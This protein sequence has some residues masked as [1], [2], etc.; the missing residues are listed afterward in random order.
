MW[1]SVAT[2]NFQAD[3]LPAEPFSF[4]IFPANAVLDP[5]IPSIT[6]NLRKASY[7]AGDSTFVIVTA[8]FAPD[9]SFASSAQKAVAFPNPW[10]ASM[11]VP[12]CMQAS[13][14]TQVEIRD[15]SGLVWQ[16]REIST[17]S[18]RACWSA[19][20][21]TLAPGVYSWRGNKEHKLHSLLIIR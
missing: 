3:L 17:S 9:A 10:R 21:M 2:T 1:P 14:S 16:S 15:A 6:S 19:A 8:G 18:L 5:W 4:R 7:R 20:E 12:L 11:G 13:G